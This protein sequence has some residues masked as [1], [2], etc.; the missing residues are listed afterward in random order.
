M[1][2]I[3]MA[4]LPRFLIRHVTTVIVAGLCGLATLPVQADAQKDGAG[5]QV[6]C[7]RSFR[8]QSVGDYGSGATIRTDWYT[9]GG[10]GGGVGVFAGHPNCLARGD[11]ALLRF[12][13]SPLFLM[14]EE[15]IARQRAVLR[16]SVSNLV[17]KA[18]ERK[19]E[20]VHLDY[21]PWSLTGNDLVNAKIQVV[22]TVGIG[23]SEYS[24]RVYSV[25]VTK[26]VQEHI[27]QGNKFS[28]F[29]FRDVEAEAHGNPDLTPEGVAI[30]FDATTPVLEVKEMK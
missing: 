23:R 12:N 5:D 7:V 18:D 20:I 29:R 6:D 1:G 25:D 8:P 14:P 15:S 10:L 16:F 24:G 13:L 17:G 21:D 27:R 2:N 28:A 11:R 9:P 19:I 3:T 26:W 4:E 30:L 22:T